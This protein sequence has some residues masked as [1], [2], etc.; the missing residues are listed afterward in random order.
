MLRYIGK[1]FCLI[2][3]LVFAGYGIFLSVLNFAAPVSREYSQ[4]YSFVKIAELRAL[5]A[6]EAICQ[7]LQKRSDL[8]FILR[9]E[10]NLNPTSQKYRVS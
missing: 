10:K 7:N 2:V 1:F 3:L 8:N 9:D 5:K 6:R 4:R